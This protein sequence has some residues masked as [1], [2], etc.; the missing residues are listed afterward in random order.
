MANEITINTTFK[1]TKGYLDLTR[2]LAITPTLTASAPNVA[3]FTQ[4]IG[5]AA[6]EAIAVGDVATLGW[7]WFKNLGP[8]NFV[9][10][11]PYSGGALVPFVRLLVG[12]AAL[13]R[14]TPG[15]TIHAQADT[16]GIVLEKLIYDA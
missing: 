3:G 4:A 1:V 15:I 5:F 16:A 12:E 14:L 13:L 10:I 9:D 8:T 6:S 7:A 11:G 2:Q